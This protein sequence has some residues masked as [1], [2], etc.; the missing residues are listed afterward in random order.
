MSPSDE[1]ER[2]LPCKEVLAMSQRC[3]N[4]VIM[5]ILPEKGINGTLWNVMGPV[6]NG[7]GKGNGRSRNRYTGRVGR[8]GGGS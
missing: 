7:D 8:Q 2:I 5:G 4:D 6:W 3:R 1:R